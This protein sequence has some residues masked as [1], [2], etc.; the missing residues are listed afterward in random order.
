MKTISIIVP[1]YNGE[2]TI[3]KCI[4]SLVSQ[5]ITIDEIIVVDDGSTDSTPDI[6]KSLSEQNSNIRLLSCQ[7]SGVSAAR[8]LGLSLATGKYIGFVDAD[9]YSEPDM[10]ETLLKNI[11]A[12][13]SDCCI[14][15]FFT[16]KEGI[17]TPLSYG[18]S[19]EISLNELLNALF[20][21]DSV[22]GFIWNR[23]F[24][25]GVLADLTFD[26]SIAMCE[27]KLYQLELFTTRD[28]KVTVE[29]KPLYHYIQ[30]DCSST[31]SLSYFNNGRFKYKDSFDRM[32]SVIDSSVLSSS[33]KER[34]TAALYTNYR[35]I[36]EYSM[37]TLL[38]SNDISKADIILLKEEMLH[39][40]KTIFKKSF[41]SSAEKRHYLLLS[42][43]PLLYK[44]LRL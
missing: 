20:I 13:N 35:S 9:D 33:E 27:D 14:C 34:L 31:G 37:Y 4:E 25:R 44:K 41:V 15:G 10:Y 11:I 28:I 12:N 8:N 23:L 1:V 43:M 18:K 17:S 40:Q 36:L 16:E 2:K 32:M 19:G 7:N 39:M 21:S 26:S 3:K 38:T 5:T 22:G 42:H 29:D 24:K 30:S 6:I